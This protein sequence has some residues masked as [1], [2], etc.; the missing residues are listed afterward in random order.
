MAYSEKDIEAKL[1]IRTFLKS[2]P[3]KAM[4]N[5]PFSDGGLWT[6]DHTLLAATG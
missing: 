1:I 2:A 3:N 6:D 4:S 5:A